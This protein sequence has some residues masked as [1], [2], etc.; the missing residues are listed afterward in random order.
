VIPSIKEIPAM[1]GCSLKGIFLPLKNK[2]PMV[3]VI[4]NEERVMIPR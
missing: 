2:R 4:M 3:A 1:V